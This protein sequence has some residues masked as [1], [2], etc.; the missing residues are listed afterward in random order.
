MAKDSGILSTGGAALLLLPILVFS[1]TTQ[2]VSLAYN[3]TNNL[4]LFDLSSGGQIVGLRPYFFCEDV[5]NL[6]YEGDFSLVDFEPRNLLMANT[7]A[8]SKVV[9]LPGV[10]NRTTLYSR[11]YS[12]YAPS[13]SLYGLADAV[14][15]DSIRMYVGKFLLMPDARVRYKY[16]YSDLITSYIEPRAKV[17]LRIPLPYAFL[18]PSASAG[19]RIYDEESTPFFTTSA[20]LFFPLSVDF[21]LST[22]FTFGQTTAPDSV[23][24][25][26]AL[27]IDDPFFEE[28]NIEKIYDL[29]LALNR[30][31]IR[32][33]T[34]IE[35]KGNLFRKNFLEVNGEGR[36][37]EGISLSLQ[38]T[39]F[40][41]ST[42][43]FHV[44]MG[45]LL[46]SST[47]PEFDFMK[48][49]LE[50]IFELIL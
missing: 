17:G 34:F 8:L 36:T 3:L 35:L 28:E 1:Y 46:N 41:S 20:Q 32:Q 10:G 9:L 24:I 2:G 48:N 22:A 5:F 43:V 7:A 45:T 21:S 50:L 37:D 33:R 40:V 38:Y 39:K 49:D 29:E 19:M 14:F 6:D 13:Y 15:G 23:F 27:Y 42:F 4:N 44:T 16:F 12:F 18:T 31:V 47:R 30:S 25:V 26:P 11:L